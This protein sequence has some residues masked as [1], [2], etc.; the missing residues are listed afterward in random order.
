MWTFASVLF[1]LAGVGA[2]AWYYAASHAREAHP[3][4]PEV[5]PLHNLSPTPSMKATI[6]YFWV[7]VAL[8]A[9]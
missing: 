5:N 8:F 3:S 9:L 7:V 4:P 1:L 2:L 6:K